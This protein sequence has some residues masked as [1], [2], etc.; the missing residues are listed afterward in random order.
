MTKDKIFFID[1]NVLIYALEKEASEK[2]E[3]AKSIIDE[4]FDGKNF[5]AVSN[6]IL[7]EFFFIATEKLKVDK[8]EAKK[9]MEK[10]IER[11][12]ITKTRYTEETTLSAVDIQKESKMPFWDSLI[13]ATMLENNIGTIYT[14]N[15]RDFSIAGITAINPFS[16][17]SHS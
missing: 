4:C 6:Q 10:I 3:I 7:A 1:T 5:L 12:T 11:E 14:E 16:K 9:V 17:S 2:K 13:A 15:T 8:N